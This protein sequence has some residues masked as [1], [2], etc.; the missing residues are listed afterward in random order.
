MLLQTFK[1]D[2]TY[3]V[4]VGEKR[5][6]STPLLTAFIFPPCKTSVKDAITS[7]ASPVA[8]YET[9]DPDMF[10]GARIDA[11]HGTV[12]A[13]F[14]DNST[15]PVD[16]LTL[17][18]TSSTKPSISAFIEGNRHPLL[19]ELTTKNYDAIFKSSTRPLIV[20]AAL[21]K[22]SRGFDADLARFRDIARAWYKGGRKFKQPVWFV[23]ADGTKWKKWFGQTY[24]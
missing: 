18:S 13:A 11:Q 14:K 19:L 4:S 7:L 15:R 3:A 20:L 24:G 5:S 6:P 16:S 22:S 17:T 21:K 2:P 8:V 10:K 1:S 9:H 12:L 23:W